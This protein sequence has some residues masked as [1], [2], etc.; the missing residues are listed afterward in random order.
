[1]AR[2]GCLLKAIVNTQSPFLKTNG[3]NFHASILALLQ[4]Y[5]QKWLMLQ[6]F[7]DERLQCEGEHGIVV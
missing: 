4:G 7:W 5:Q 1:M 3:N 2:F 6:L